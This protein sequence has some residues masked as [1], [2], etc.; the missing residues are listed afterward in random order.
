M[1]RFSFKLKQQL[2][3]PRKIYSIDSGMLAATAFMISE[4]RGRILENLV[5]V[6]LVRRKHY[7]GEG[8]EKYLGKKIRFLPLPYFFDLDVDWREN[9]WRKRSFRRRKRRSLWSEKPSGGE[10]TILTIPSFWRGKMTA[11]IMLFVLPFRVATR[12]GPSRSELR[13]SWPKLRLYNIRAWAE[14]C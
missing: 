14:A 12:N 10:R 7:R 3:S 6:E 11:G 8:E 2:L 13:K 5:A 9:I 1:E 4:D